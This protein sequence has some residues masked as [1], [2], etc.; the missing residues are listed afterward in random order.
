MFAVGYLCYVT[1]T[2]TMKMHFI[3]GPTA[4]QTSMAVEHRLTYA[5]K[6]TTSRLSLPPGTKQIQT[7]V[8]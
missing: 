4:D 5:Q 3:W 8:K 2:Y 6:L 7:N 1:Q